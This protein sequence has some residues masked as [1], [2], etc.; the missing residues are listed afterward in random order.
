MVKAAKE[1]QQIYQSLS[2]PILAGMLP[3]ENDTFENITVVLTYVACGVAIVA[4]IL[5]A[6]ATYKLKTVLA[7][8]A[9]MQKVQSAQASILP[10]DFQ[11][12][13]STVKTLLTTTHCDHETASYWW[14]I[15]V[16]FLSL[17]II[18]LLRRTW[19]RRGTTL[20]LEISN[21]DICERI[22]IMKIQHCPTTGV[23]LHIS[24]IARGYR[25]L[26]RAIRIFVFVA[27]LAIR[28]D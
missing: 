1:D 28:K 21:A 16:L 17:V 14:M 25:K 4:F 18:E 10:Y 19:K 5:A 3:N 15:V 26:S 2:E 12:P 23:Q 20:Y 11:F 6:S 9:S 8:V 7:V 13:T 24:P 22:E 27:R